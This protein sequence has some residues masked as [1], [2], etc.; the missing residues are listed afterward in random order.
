MS[1]YSSSGAKHNFKADFEGGIQHKVFLLVI[2]PTLN[3]HRKACEKE[4]ARG[5]WRQEFWN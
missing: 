1:Y 4:W 5:V 2:F 3:T